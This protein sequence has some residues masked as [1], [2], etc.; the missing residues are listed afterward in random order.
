MDPVRFDRLSKAVFRAGTRRRLLGLLS[1]AP[2]LASLTLLLSPE[3]SEAT[4]PA[5]RVLRRKEQRRRKARKQRRKERHQQQKQQKQHQSDGEGGGT[6]AAPG[7]TCVPLDQ[8]CTIEVTTC[9]GGGEKPFPH[10]CGGTG[11]FVLFT[12][13]KG[14]KQTVDCQR[15]LGWEDVS[16]VK[17]DWACASR[18]GHSCCRPNLCSRTNQCRSGGPCCVTLLGEERCCAPGQTCSPFGGCTFA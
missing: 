11:A 9:C 4:H 1:T 13:Q 6:P 2:V 5:N 15:E 18:P 8:V 17:D 10:Q 14:C 3:A 16:C 12:C 7:G